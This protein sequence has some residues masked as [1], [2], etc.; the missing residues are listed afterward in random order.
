MAGNIGILLCLL[1]NFDRLILRVFDRMMHIFDLAFNVP[2]RY[3][4]LVILVAEQF[5]FILVETF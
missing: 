3:S 1:D 4:D 2:D 5:I